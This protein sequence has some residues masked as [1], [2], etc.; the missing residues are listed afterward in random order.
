MQ[1]APEQ[2]TKQPQQGQPPASLQQPMFQ[3]TQPPAAHPTFTPQSSL[4]Q[5]AKQAMPPR[6]QPQ[7]QQTAVQ[8]PQP[9]LLQKPTPPQAPAVSQAPVQAVVRT[10]RL[11]ARELAQ[12]QQGQQAQEQQERAQTLQ[13][14]ARQVSA[15]PAVLDAVLASS[16]TAP[17]QAST[18]GVGSGLAQALAGLSKSQLNSLAGLL[19]QGELS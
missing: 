4:K 7:L 1:Q 17:V 14:V 18:T 13:Q 11:S 10:D 3:Q 9:A 8:L 2:Y 15:S 19:G 12:T 16:A 6:L 5:P